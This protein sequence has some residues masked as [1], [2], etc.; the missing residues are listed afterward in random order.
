[1][2]LRKVVMVSA[3]VKE[4]HSLY[5]LVSI[6]QGQRTTWSAALDHL[7]SKNISVFPTIYTYYDSSV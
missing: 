4:I 6:Q 1:M 3:M 2:S 7:V 5:L